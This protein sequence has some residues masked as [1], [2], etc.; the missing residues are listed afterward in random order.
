MNTDLHREVYPRL[1]ND[2]SFKE[3]KE[4]LRQGVCPEC[5]K[6]ELY[7]NAEQPWILRCGRLNKCGAE[8]HIKEL[9]PELFES[10]SDR[11]QPTP[12]NPNAAADAYMRDAR[13]FDVTHIK[14]WYS[15]Q[16]YYN[17]RIVL[18]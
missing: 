12:Q 2:F 14:G 11:Y 10:W 5:G 9:Y 15:Q 18:S 13:G 8:I 17:P 7:T 16:S 3:G 1:L 6:K 4:F